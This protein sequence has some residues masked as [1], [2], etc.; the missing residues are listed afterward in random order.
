MYVYSNTRESYGDNA[1][2]YAQIRRDNNI[3]SMKARICPEH[4]INESGYRVSLD[5]DEE[6]DIIIDVNCEDCPA[7]KGRNKD[8]FHF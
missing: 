7:A 5:V 6:A 3:C 4:K 1:I 8:D 2:G